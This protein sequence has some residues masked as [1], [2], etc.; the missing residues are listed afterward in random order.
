VSRLLRGRCR[1]RHYATVSG[2]RVG[3]YHGRP[4]SRSEPHGAERE[5]PNNDLTAP[6]DVLW[7]G[8]LGDRSVGCA[9]LRVLADQVGEITRVF[10]ERDVRR[11]GIGR[12]SAG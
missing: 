5:F 2:G 7:I 8:W 6:S 4:L 11:H 3:R 1:A 10:V 9:G 12:A